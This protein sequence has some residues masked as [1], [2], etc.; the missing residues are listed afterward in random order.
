MLLG[1]CVMM[2]I[3][4]VL[5]D[6]KKQKNFLGYVGGRRGQ[7]LGEHPVLGLPYG[8]SVS[9]ELEIA[10]FLLFCLLERC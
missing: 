7:S 10:P 5:L 9:S 4:R 1:R 3:V 2:A 8:V 6:G